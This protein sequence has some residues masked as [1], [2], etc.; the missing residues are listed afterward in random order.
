MQM[1]CLFAIKPICQEIPDCAVSIG[2]GG[3]ATSQD[4]FGDADEPD[5]Q[6]DERDR[7]ARGGDLG[8]PP[9]MP[10]SRNAAIVSMPRPCA[11]KVQ[12]RADSRGLAARELADIGVR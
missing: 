8:G 5:H 4:H 7:I 3:A 12:S 9:G 2:D 11:R 6:E 1:R 10:G